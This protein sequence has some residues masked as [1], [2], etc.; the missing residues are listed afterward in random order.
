[1]T[2]LQRAYYN[3]WEQQRRASMLKYMHFMNCK[4]IIAKI[5]KFIEAGGNPQ[6]SEEYKDAYMYLIGEFGEGIFLSEINKDVLTKEE[7]TSI[8]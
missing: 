4:P 1:M 2:S 5:S 8:S 6:E 7:D 3:Y